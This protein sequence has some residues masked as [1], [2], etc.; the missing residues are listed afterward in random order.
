[1]IQD[2]MSGHAAMQITGAQT[3]YTFAYVLTE[4]FAQIKILAG[5]SEAHLNNSS[6]RSRYG[7][8]SSPL[9]ASLA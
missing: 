8:I 4:G 7:S 1:M 5:N 9:L 6:R 2:H 3:F